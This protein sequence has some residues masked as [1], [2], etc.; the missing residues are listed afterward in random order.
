VPFDAGY[1]AA[2][3]HESAACVHSA[4]RVVVVEGSA[5]CRSADLSQSANFQRTWIQGDFPVTIWS[6]YDNLG[7]RTANIAEV[8]HNSLNSRFGMSHPSLRLFSTACRSTSSRY[9]FAVCRWQ[10]AAHRKRDLQSTPNS[11]LTCG[12]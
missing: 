4:T 10:Q 3:G 1:T 5:V 11:T 7:P 6:H 12:Q 8:F 2:A 9:S